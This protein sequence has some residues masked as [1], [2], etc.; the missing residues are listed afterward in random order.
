[1]KCANVR[2]SLEEYFEGLT[3]GRR[4][5]AIAEHVAGC[6]ACAAELR[7][8]ER[9]A[10]ALAVVREAQPPREML[11][12]VSVRIASLPAPAQRRIVAGWR[13]VG[14]IAA[15][16]VAVL[17]AMSYVAPI[18]ISESLASTT[19][20]IGWLGEASFF[21]RHW[22]AAAPGVLVA[23]WTA[24]EK[25]WQWFALTVRATAPTLGLYIVAELGILAAVVFVARSRGG[26]VARQALVV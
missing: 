9:V 5:A 26:T 3:A 8:I 11:R 1:M 19:L 13:R 16:F 22:F 12:A 6:A 17:G 18:L 23:F 4:A 10:A 20:P 14:L 25:V 21:L 2:L 7:Q 15:A 24:A